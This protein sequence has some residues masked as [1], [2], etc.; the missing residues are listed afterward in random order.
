MAAK[1]KVPESRRRW[2]CNWRRLRGLESAPAEAWLAKPPAQW[3]MARGRPPGQAG[4]RVV[5]AL[6]I[7]GRGRVL[8][9]AGW[10][11]RN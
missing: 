6:L 5:A 1:P 8:Q 10:L 4:S 3:G 7:A 2:P 9:G 11:S